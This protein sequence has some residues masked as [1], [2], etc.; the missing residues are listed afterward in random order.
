M[1]PINIEYFTD[2]FCIW[3]Y[4]DE[5]RVFEVKQEYG[6]RVAI[7]RHFLS[8]FGNVEDKIKNSFEGSPQ[9]FN[10]HV[11]EVAADF[12]HMS[13]HKD[14]FLKNMPSS[15]PNC[16]PFIKALQI[17]IERGEVEN[18]VP[19]FCSEIRKA[20][21]GELRD[22][23]NLGVL[24]EHTKAHGIKEKSIQALLNSGEAMA[25][26]VLDRKLSEKYK[27]KGSPSYVLNGGRQTLFGNVGY[28][29]IRANIEELLNEKPKEY[30]SWC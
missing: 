27:L 19:S 1:L 9:K 20:Y 7:H 30:A 12:E 11:R 22:I 15:S 5:A 23:S 17:L 3:A 6:D 10:A 18:I 26:I 29:L 14:F 2:V 24:F 4:V 25:Q 16:H 28:R 13:V 8:V 21:F